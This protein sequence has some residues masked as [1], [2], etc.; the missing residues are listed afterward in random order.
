MNEVDF[1]EK[2]GEVREELARMNAR[3]ENLDRRIDD[4][5][6]SQVRDHGKRIS[7]LEQKQA[8]AAGAIAL[9]GG[10][11]AAVCAALQLILR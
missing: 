3:I 8:W 6:V 9:A 11:G 1:M 10:V 4:A 5:V 7:A 2:L